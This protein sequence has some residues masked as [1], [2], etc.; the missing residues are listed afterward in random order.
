MALEVAKLITFKWLYV[1]PYLGLFGPLKK[2]RTLIERQARTSVDKLIAFMNL[3]VIFSN[4]TCFLIDVLLFL[5]FF[6]FVVCF[7]LVCYLL[8]FLFSSF[9]YY[10]VLC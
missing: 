8:F 9:S 5:F 6:C 3:S 7:F 2:D 10:L 4:T 1:F